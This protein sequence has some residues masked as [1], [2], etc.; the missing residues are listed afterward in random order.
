MNEER[1]HRAVSRDGTQIVGRV[2]G[3][4]PPL[5]MLP[6]GPGDSETTWRH[7]LPH[8]S[9]RFTCYTM[10]T[11]GRG[12]SA[13]HPDHSPER[14]AQDVI[15]FAESIGEP[16][17]LVEWGTVVWTLAAA[18]K[19]SAIA[20]IA[21]Y[22][23]GVDEV[24][25]E[26]IATTFQRVF[27]RASELVAEGRLAD[28]ARTFIENA[29]V[30]YG[31]EELADGAPLDFWLASA[32]NIAVF[33]EEQGLAAASERPGPTDP[34]V[35]AEI[36]VPVLLLYGSRSR[37][38]FGDSVRHLAQHVRDSVVR[39]IPAQHFAPYLE[40]RTIADELVRFFTTA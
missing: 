22:D 15:G 40:P 1:I 31:D 16:V 28:A 34:F 30:V 14:L 29:T 4:G 21:A 18:Q 13:D 11:R 19:S 26:E 37:R 6:A 23:P 24:I 2:H 12:L 3:E 27:A 35:L 36:E 33:L 38:W 9:K 20:A 8:L 10:D 17:V 7:V 25:T 39:E 32:H 5:V